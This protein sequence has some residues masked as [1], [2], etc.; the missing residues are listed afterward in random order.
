[1]VSCGAA[2]AAAP[3]IMGAFIGAGMEIF[4]QTVVQGKK[5]EEIHTTQLSEKTLPSM[6]EKG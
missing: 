2:T 4:M 3:Y 5:I 1:V 6:H